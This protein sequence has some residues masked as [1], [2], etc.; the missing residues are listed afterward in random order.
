MADK[1]K[2]KRDREPPLVMKRAVFADNEAVQ[3]ATERARQVGGYYGN[4]AGDV[5]TNRAVFN[6]FVM[7]D[8]ATSHAFYAWRHAETRRQYIS[9][10]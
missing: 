10:Q 4:R 7:T 3:N 8:L 1:R 5:R 9:R 6:P 2:M